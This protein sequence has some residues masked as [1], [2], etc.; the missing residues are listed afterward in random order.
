M[1]ATV[2]DEAKLLPESARFRTRNKLADFTAHD[3][4]GSPGVRGEPTTIVDGALE[5]VAKAYEYR[6]LYNQNLGASVLTV[7]VGVN[8]MLP[9]GPAIG[10]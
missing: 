6:R 2:E 5:V 3:L 8:P 7:A 1:F 4:N 10:R 9:I